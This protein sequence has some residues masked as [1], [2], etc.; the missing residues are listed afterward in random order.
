M[1]MSQSR[2]FDRI[3]RPAADLTADLLAILLRMG[4]E[5]AYRDTVNALWERQP[6]YSQFD[7]KLVPPRHV[8][9]DPS[10]RP[11]VDRIFAAYQKAKH[12]ESN[13]DPVFLPE[14][15]WKRVVESAYA[16][17]IQGCDNND[18]ERFHFFL[19]NF[20]A[21]DRPTGIEESSVFRRIEESGRK[22]KHF[23]Q[24][25]M[26]QLIQ[27]WETFESNGRSL[28]ELTIP[29]FGNQA[30]VLVNGHFILPNSV[31]SEFYGRLLAGFVPQQQPMI[32]ELGGGYGRLYYFISRHLLQ[33]TYVAF[34]LPECLCCASYYLL[35][36]F[37][38]KRFFLYGE[39]E[40][41]PEILNEHDFILL[42]AFE[43]AKLKEGS[44]DLFIN[45]NSLGMMKPAACRRFVT[46][47]CRSA[48]AFW[49]R[50][51]E[52]RRFPFA[53]GTTS[54]INRE[55]PIDR[56]RFCEVIRYCDIARLIG[57]SRST[58]KNDMVWYYYR[59]RTTD[60]ERCSADLD[61]ARTSG[62]TVA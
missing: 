18:V 50:N 35:M 41:T 47:I 10:E 20:G 52:V 13:R 36:A 14:G 60:D 16:D 38:N 21:W 42:P 40:L 19:A 31:F 30:G 49:H 53:D 7:I 22:K 28:S 2:L 62:E 61:L 27:W 46:E 29:R 58:I 56:D 24:Q 4:G 51:H 48:K 57:H 26:A 8:A 54:L 17:L 43:I 34:D 1:P 33:P 23:E 25:V 5:N 32:G 9:P 3:K 45:E 55:Y 59:T 15:G 11:L 44:V 39:G 37:P 6:V 12:D